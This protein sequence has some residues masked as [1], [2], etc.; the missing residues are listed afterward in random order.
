MPIH[1]EP[2]LFAL[3]ALA[4]SL[5]QLQPGDCALT[6]EEHLGLKGLGFAR[7]AC[8]PQSCGAE[9]QLRCERFTQV[10]PP[11]ELLR[12]LADYEGDIS[13]PGNFGIC[14]ANWIDFELGVG[15]FGGRQ[16]R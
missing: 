1:V 7:S 12:P 14:W 9:A 3:L 15:R 6:A 2:K 10:L 16:S 8:T 5:D 4:A 11:V 13:G